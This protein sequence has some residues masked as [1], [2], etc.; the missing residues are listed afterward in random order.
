MVVSFRNMQ[1]PNVF[2]S[3]IL[4]LQLQ[5]LEHMYPPETVGITGRFILLQ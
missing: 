1:H 4:G 5:K 3:N 2:A